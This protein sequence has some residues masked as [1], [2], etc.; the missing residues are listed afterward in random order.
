MDLVLFEYALEH[1]Q[2]IGRCLMT[3]R[4]SVM[5]IGVGG[6]GKQSCVRLATF[7]GRHYKTKQ[8]VLVRNYDKKQFLED[9]KEVWCDAAKAIVDNV[10]FLLTDNDIKKDE[11]LEN[12][13]SFLNTGEIANMLEKPDRDTACGEAEKQMDIPRGGET[14]PPE[15]LYDFA[16]G[17]VMD[18]L[19][20]VLAFSPKH[21]KY[22]ERGIKF[23][24]LFTTCALNYF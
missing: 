2:R 12:I 7:M 14:P 5:L 21:P 15:I 11:F 22:R 18:A 19:H 23:P 17:K 8:I 10:T 3:P 16:V 4:N 20:I 1:V 6:S 9:V 13:N 24:S